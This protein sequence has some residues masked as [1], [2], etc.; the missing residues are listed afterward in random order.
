[1]LEQLDRQYAS[2]ELEDEND[3]QGKYISLGIYFYEQDSS[4]E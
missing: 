3:D 4:E 1:L 2:H